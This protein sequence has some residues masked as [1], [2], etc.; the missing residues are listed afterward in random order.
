MQCGR[1]LSALQILRKD[2][3]QLIRALHE[4]GDRPGQ[5]NDSSEI[6]ESLEFERLQH[7]NADL[8]QNFDKTLCST[9]DLQRNCD[10]ARNTLSEIQASHALQEAEAVATI[11]RLENDIADYQSRIAGLEH[12]LSHAGSNDRLQQAMDALEMVTLDKEVAEE[13][14]LTYREELI[15]V[16]D[17]LADITLQRD[18]MQK[19]QQLY[20]ESSDNDFSNDLKP[21]TMLRRMHD[22]EQQNTQLRVALLRLRNFS[23]AAS[24]TSQSSQLSNAVQENEKL[25]TQVAELM[26]NVDAARSS[27]SIITNLTDKQM[28][29][30]E[31]IDYLMQERQSLLTTCSLSEQLIQCH[32]LVEKELHH[33]LAHRDYLLK[34]VLRRYKELQECNRVLKRTLLEYR[35]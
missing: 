22:L 34:M 18:I 17:K 12:Q 32:A 8:Q 7:A 31:R 6:S 24:I 13:R 15:E 1:Q 2:V 14:A 25:R 4:R 16:R 5:R 10:T 26:Q 33:E 21:S 27:D 9:A 28:Q 11:R 35:E 3:H 20:F 29:L 23:M 30:G 19:N